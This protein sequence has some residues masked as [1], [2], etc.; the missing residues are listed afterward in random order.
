M[1]WTDNMD[2]AL[3]SIRRELGDKPWRKVAAEFSKR[4]GIAVSADTVRN[5]YSRIEDELDF[6]TLAPTEAVEKPTD[7]AGFRIAFYDIE[8]TD[9]GALMG[10]VLAISIV[11]E[12]GV[13]TH[14]TYADFPGKNILD[15]SGLIDWFLEELEQYDMVVTW[16]GKLFDQPFINARALKGLVVPPRG[17]NS[18]MHL[19]LMYVFKGAKVRFGSAKLD[20]VARALG[21]ANQKTPLDF[22]TWEKASVGD[23]D[24]LALVQEHCDADVRTMRDVFAYPGVK[25]LVTQVYRG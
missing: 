23:M 10:R 3:Y 1:K 25:R 19:D 17:G 2:R 13:L 22:L 15:D 8:T 14:R 7:Y 6:V 11:D 16:N 20:N 5:R 24:A 9:L 21:V 12:F 18:M 4:T